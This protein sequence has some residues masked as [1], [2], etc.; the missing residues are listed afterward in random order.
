MN[1]LSL[2]PS[3]ACCHQF[4]LFSVYGLIIWFGGLDINA[5]RASFDDMLKAF[6]AILLAAMG[7]AQSASGVGSVWRV[8]QAQEGKQAMQSHTFS[9]CIQY[10]LSHHL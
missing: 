5:G 8:K 6:L 2:N 10:P 3:C 7:F 4:S 9:L 1:S